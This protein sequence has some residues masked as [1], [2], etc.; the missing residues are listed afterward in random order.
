MG[1]NDGNISVWRLSERAPEKPLLL[2]KNASGELIEDITW[3]SDGAVLMATTMKRYF[4]LAVFE[5]KG[6]LG[7]SLTQ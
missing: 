5:E 7:T 2:L 1:D 4:I 3:S 6:V